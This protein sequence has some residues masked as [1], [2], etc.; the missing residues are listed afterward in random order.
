VQVPG[1]RGALAEWRSWLSLFASETHP[2]PH[3]V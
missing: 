1:R 2:H 3:T